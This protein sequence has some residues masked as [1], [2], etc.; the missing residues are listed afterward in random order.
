MKKLEDVISQFSTL[1][2]EEKIEFL[3]NLTFF[4]GIESRDFYDKNPKQSIEK[5]ILLNEGMIDTLSKLK[6]LVIKKYMNKHS[7]SDDKFIEI[8]Y[9]P[10]KKQVIDDKVFYRAVYDSFKNLDKFQKK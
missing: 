9:E 3:V 6:P 1:N 4:L 8:I 7:Y 2:K 10:F 5:L